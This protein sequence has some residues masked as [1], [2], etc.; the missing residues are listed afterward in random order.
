MDVSD[1][2][3]VLLVSGSPVGVDAQLL[4][5]L[6][7]GMSFITAVDSGAQWCLNAGLIPDLLVGDLD[8]LSPEA[9]LTLA[10]QEVEEKVYDSLKD[11][12][13]LELAL[14]ELVQRGYTDLVATNVVGGRLDHELA[15]LGNL[16]AAGTQGLAVTLVEPTQTL[17]FLNTPGARQ[18]LQIDFGADIDAINAPFVS[19]IAWGGP[20]S[21]SLSGFQW[22][23][24]HVVL[25]PFSSLGVSNVPT[26]TNSLIELHEGALIVAIQTPA[27]L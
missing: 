7:E 17:V 13:D 22:E 9:R 6:A 25:D 11:A 2:R 3:F 24:D 20:A 21:V 12:S 8:S 23:L 14:T 18:H 4:W 16:A 5:E 1:K 26:A 15:A 10:A 27:I 19:L